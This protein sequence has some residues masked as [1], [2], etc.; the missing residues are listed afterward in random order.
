MHVQTIDCL[1]HTA[2]FNRVPKSHEILMFVCLQKDAKQ[3]CDAT[4]VGCTHCLT[5]S[6]QQKN[7]NIS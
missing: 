2:M 3:C 7:I 6:W 4:K 1:V 5:T